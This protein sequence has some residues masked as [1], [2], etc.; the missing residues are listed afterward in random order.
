VN[1]GIAFGFTLASSSRE[2]CNV[3]TDRPIWRISTSGWPASRSAHPPLAAAVTTVFTTHATATGP[4][5]RRR[6]IRIVYE[7][8]AVLNGDARRTKYQILPRHL[9]E[10]AAAQLGRRL[11]DRQRSDG[12]RGVTASWA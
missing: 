12:A 2:L 3:V 9:I 11:H 4:V 10:K 1:G 6:Q 7:Q 5:P 8:L